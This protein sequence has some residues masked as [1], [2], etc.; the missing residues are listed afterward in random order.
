MHAVAHHLGSGSPAA[1]QA[2]ASRN[3]H[4]LSA[5]EITI[6]RLGADRQ[7]LYTLANDAEKN[8]EE[9]KSN[10]AGTAIDPEG[11]ICQLLTRCI[12]TAGRIFR[13]AT[14]KHKAACAVSLLTPEDGVAD[15]YVEYI[16]SLREFHD[17]MAAFLEWVE[18]HDALLEAPGD[19]TYGNA[20]ELF[21]ALTSRT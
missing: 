9:L 2:F 12:E 13:D 16:D 15:T 18:S 17:V 6:D 20:D 4:F 8:L 19:R 5:I 1:V 21:E 3:L 10:P 7:I 14:E 11:R